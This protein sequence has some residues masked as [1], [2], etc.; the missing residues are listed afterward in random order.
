MYPDD[1]PSVDLCLWVL[2]SVRPSRF[3]C[4]CWQ[5]TRKE[6]HKMW[7][8]DVSKRFT[9]VDIDADGYCCNFMHLSIRPTIQGIEFGYCRQ[10][11]YIWACWCIQMT[12]YPSTASMPIGIVV[13]SC[14]RP[15]VQLSMNLGFGIAEDCALPSDRN[16]TILNTLRPRPND[17]H[18][19]DDIFKWIFLNENV[20]I[21]DNISLKFVR[22]GPINNIPALF[23]IM[24]WR[25]L[26]DKPLSEPMIA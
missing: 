3:L 26:G 4:I 14:V 25:R 7:H 19:P 2:L 18:F 15:S 9:S 13:I 5:I 1:L 6:W 20:W 8:V 17:R 21:S 22:R 23:Q 10:M 12:Y 11:V 24:A 16:R